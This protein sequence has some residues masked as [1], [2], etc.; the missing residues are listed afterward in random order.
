[1]PILTP[2][3]CF[4]NAFDV[5][6]DLCGK[7]L[8]SA[9]ALD[10]KLQAG[11]EFD[12]KKI[13]Y[14]NL[15]NPHALGQDPIFYFREVMGLAS[16]PHLFDDESTKASFEPEVIEHARKISESFGRGG[17]GK[18]TDTQGVMFARKSV[19][20]YISKRDGYPAKPEDIY[21]CDGATPGIQMVL[22]IALREKTD[23]V[24]I[25]IP[26]YPLYNACITL[27]DGAACP[28]YL[29]EEKD[30]ALT[31]EEMERAH[32]EAVKK[33][34]NPRVCVVV[35]PGNPT[36]NVLNVEIMKD[37]AKFCHE[38]KMLLLADEVYQRN[39]YMPEE[40]PWV[41]FK[42]IVC[43]LGLDKKGFELC[44]VHSTSKGMVGE[45]GRR[46]GYFELINVSDEVR[47][48]I[49]KLTSLLCVNSAG[50]IMTHLMVSA[51]Q[52]KGEGKARDACYDQ[53]KG[54]FESLQRKA[55]KLHKF[56]TSLEGVTCCSP[57][58]ALYLF[59]RITIPEKAIHK[60]KEE[61]I[62]ADEL[63]C[64]EML[65]STGLLVMP[66]SSFGQKEGTYHFRT[67][68]LMGEDDLEDVLPLLKKFHTGFMSKYE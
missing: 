23:G 11:E 35:N 13:I 17:T 36:G 2:G 5:K 28:Y 62:P 53:Y 54:I 63:Y 15:G 25:P 43:D 33:G 46:G 7:L 48:A 58:G 37:I 10:A 68:I 19:A 29:D 56:F 44:S 9:E 20:E 51:P 38:K 64:V 8:T 26:Q 45:C 1:M 65:E 27:Y 31:L 3:T 47:S 14:S 34:I 61:G 49:L 55:K 59:P 30:W 6:F 16:M 57:Q 12:F 50:Q 22:R 21:M 60:A 40:F 18:Y 32:A 67:T 42:K 24:M 66:G 52:K 41:S 39:I 4:K